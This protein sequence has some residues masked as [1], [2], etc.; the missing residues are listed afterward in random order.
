M[1]LVERAVSPMT[2]PVVRSIIIHGGVGDRSR[3]ECRSSVRPSPS[4]R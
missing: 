2:T 3:G 4:E 1:L